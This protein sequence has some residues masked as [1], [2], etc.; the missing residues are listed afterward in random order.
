MPSGP[1][2]TTTAVKNARL[3]SGSS[4]LDSGLEVSVGSCP[5]ANGT[6]LRGDDA[7]IVGCVKGEGSVGT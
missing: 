1:S 3:V 4:A 2:S 6:Y 7:A 5:G